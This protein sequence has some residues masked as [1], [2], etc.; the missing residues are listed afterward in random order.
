MWAKIISYSKFGLL[1]NSTVF[2]FGLTEISIFR[3]FMLCTQE[4]KAV[5]LEHLPQSW[6]EPSLAFWELNLQCERL[7]SWTGE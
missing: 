3:L 5:N 2:L 4:F 6:R 7:L 1:R